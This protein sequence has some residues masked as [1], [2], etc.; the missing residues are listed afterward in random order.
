M[1]WVLLQTKAKRWR[2]GNLWKISKEYLMRHMKK[3]KLSMVKLNNKLSRASLRVRVD[4]LSR[5]LGWLI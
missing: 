3:F 1:N 2:V 4:E 5:D